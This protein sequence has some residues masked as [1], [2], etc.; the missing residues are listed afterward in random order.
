MIMQAL[1]SGITGGLIYA[2]IAVGFSL[3]FGIARIL[4]MVHGELYMIGALLAFFAIE[5]L[6]IDYYIALVI[7][8]FL[9]G[10][11]AFLIERFIRRLHGEQLPTLIV[12][13]A[14]G[15]IISNLALLFFGERAQVVTTATLLT[16]H[17]DIFGASID[18]QRLLIIIITLLVVIGLYFLINKTLIGISI[19]ALA[20]DREA[21][22]LQG[23]NAYRSQ[24][25]TFFI[26][27]AAAGL[28][29]I[30]VAPL[31]YVDAFSSG[32]ALTKC[33]VVVVLG[34]L[35]SLPGAIAGG[36]FLGLIESFGSITI[37]G[38]AILLSFAAV[39][40]MLIVRPRGFLGRE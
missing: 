6:G 30:L 32:T 14:I 21:A 8:T 38:Y 16:G 24:A 7:I 22:I 36:L 3:I 11:F 19:R 5:I 28:A 34:G 13:L 15:M 1:V 35:G 27:G 2:L 23:I 29:G 9:V 40:I 10:I 31:Y 37:G 26:A 18:G 25:I 12:T 4:F 39:I 33:F 17:I 20:Q